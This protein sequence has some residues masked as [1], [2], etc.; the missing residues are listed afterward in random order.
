MNDA[1]K[2]NRVLVVTA[3]ICV[4]TMIAQH[5]AGKAARDALF[6][7]YFPVERLPVM[8]IVAALVSVVGVILMSKLL[9]RFGPARLIPLTFGI[10]AA[11]LLALWQIID[12]MPQVAAGLLY[13]QVSAINGLLISG[14]WSVINERFD[15]YTAKPVIARLAAGA[16]FGGL[17][18]GV[19]A[20]VVSG[21]ADTTALLL[22]LAVMHVV[23]GLALGYISAGKSTGGAAR[24]ETE[25]VGSLLS[26][27]RSSSLI[28]LMA[29]LALMIATAAAM[30]DYILKAEAAASL[31]EEQLI[32]FFSYFYVA[33][34]LGSFLLQAAI[35]DKAVKWLGLGGCMLAWPLA[36]L[37][38]GAVALVMR[39]L[40]TVTL[41]RA[42]ANL[43]YNSFFR[44]GF[45]LLYTPIPAAHKRTGKVMIDVG[46]DRAGDMIGAG[47]V[48][49]LLLLPAAISSTALLI[50]ALVLATFCAI[51]ILVLQRNYS[52]QLASN[53][54]TGTMELAQDQTQDPMLAQSLEITQQVIRRDALLEEI[55]R[56]RAAG[57]PEPDRPAAAP[58]LAGESAGEAPVAVPIPSGTDPVTE[59]ILILRGDD[60]ARIRRVLTSREL[61]PELVPHAIR[62]LGRQ[63]VV[64]E[65][66]RA[67]RAAARRS[68]GQLVDALLDSFQN[69]R[70][71]RR[72]PIVLAYSDS[73][74]AI[75]GLTAVLSDSDLNVRYRA[76]R[77]LERIRRR[78]PRADM[79]IEDL[80]AAIEKELRSL[81]RIRYRGGESGPATMR[82]LEMVFFLLGAIGDPVTVELTWNALHGEDRWLKGTA[83]EYLENRLS[84]D[85]WN[86]LKP[87]LDA[88]SE[89]VAHE[90]RSAADAARELRSAADKLKDVRTPAP[91]DTLMDDE[92]PGP[93]DAPAG[94][95]SG[96]SAAR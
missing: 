27:L 69:G 15:P 90:K 91:A 16:T 8:M 9:A 60:D 26:P 51:L 35:G 2:G 61:T 93:D 73:P 81:R 11:M 40:V 74:V 30:L 36:I 71:R 86:R 20:K 38:T 42:S 92:D 76:A 62:L 88:T 21:A 78:N 41:L 29:F 64:R 50:T 10:S 57:R 4:T 48:M 58:A 85:I 13:L 24:S 44:T 95:E 54:Q 19:L 63:G 84:I 72:L 37:M 70:V 82:R 6:L 39:T 23:C 46:A 83:L 5:I 33:V 7:T 14:F 66:L 80:N 52:Q 79:P 89:E 18:G 32:A 87:L 94:N 56:R 12:T 59:S 55:A 67:L 3:L 31:T 34:G 22:M 45:E 65:A 28:R 1:A 77:A 47:V 17:A 96:E 43:L 68:P 53:L 75:Y 49:G 25:E